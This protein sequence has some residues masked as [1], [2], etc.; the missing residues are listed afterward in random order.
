MAANMAEKW[1]QDA[2][3]QNKGALQACRPRAL[4]VPQD[5]NIPTSKL[6][7]H[8]HDSGKMGMRVRAA[9]IARKVHR[10]HMVRKIA[11]G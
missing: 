3:S 1:M 9:L 4:G 7:A 11:K 6:M 5:E 8:Q 2:F 10:R